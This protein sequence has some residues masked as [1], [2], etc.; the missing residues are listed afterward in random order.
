MK[1]FPKEMIGKIV[2][3]PD[4]KYINGYPEWCYKGEKKMKEEIKDDYNSNDWQSECDAQLV[5]GKKTTPR[6]FDKVVYHG[7]KLHTN[8]LGEKEWFH[9]GICECHK[10][11]AKKHK[12]QFLERIET[13]IIKM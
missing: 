8:C 4:T 2:I 12:I 7:R 3:L 6:C 10:E 11:Y 1:K 9:Y 5:V 13:K